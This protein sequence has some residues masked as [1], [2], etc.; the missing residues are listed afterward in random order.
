MFSRRGYLDSALQTPL[1]TH[2]GQA[3]AQT[4]NVVVFD[5]G[6][7]E[8]MWVP[9]AYDPYDYEQYMMKREGQPPNSALRDSTQADPR[10]ANANKRRQRF[11]PRQRSQQRAL[12]ISMNL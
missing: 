1:R 8:Y 2:S 5:D 7:G 12:W 4:P 9:S 6:H 11:H 3:L 10:C